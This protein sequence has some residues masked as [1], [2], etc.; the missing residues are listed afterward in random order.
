MF[1]LFLRQ[2]EVPVSPGEFFEIVKIAHLE[3]FE[4]FAILRWREFFWKIKKWSRI[5]PLQQHFSPAET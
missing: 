5:F 3:G 2:N 1:K 4:K